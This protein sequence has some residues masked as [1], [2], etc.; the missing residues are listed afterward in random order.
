MNTAT[1]VFI[2]PTTDDLIIRDPASAKPLPMAGAW[3]PR[4]AW[5]LRRLQD[6]A[7]I[8]ATPPKVISSQANTAKE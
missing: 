5:W 4:S 8:K 1:H 6:G 2:K 3:K 7:V